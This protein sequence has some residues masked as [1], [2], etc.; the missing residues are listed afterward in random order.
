MRFPDRRVLDEHLEGGFIEDYLQI[1]FAEPAVNKISH[2]V[3][4]PFQENESF[5]DKEVDHQL[6]LNQASQQVLSHIFPWCV[7]TRRLFRHAGKFEAAHV[8]A[9]L[10]RWYEYY[11]PPP[12]AEDDENVGAS[13]STKG[14]GT[15]A[16]IMELMYLEE[17]QLIGQNSQNSTLV[18]EIQYVEPDYQVTDH[19][20][21]VESEP[22][23]VVFQEENMFPNRAVT[24]TMTN[25]MLSQSTTSIGNESTIGMYGNEVPD[26]PY[27]IYQDHYNVINMPEAWKIMKDLNAWPRAKYV[28]VHI[29]DS[30]WDIDHV[31]A[32]DNKWVNPDEDCTDDQKDPNKKDDDNNG[33]SDDCFGYNFADDTGSNIKGSN[34]HGSHCAGTISANTYNNL[35]VAGVAGGNKKNKGVQIMAGVVFGNSRN[36]GI[37]ESMTYGADMGAHISSNSWGFTTAGSYPQ[38]MKDAIAYAVERGVLVVFAAGNNGSSQKYY[39]AADDRV[40][41]VGSIEDNKKISDFSNWGDWVNIAAPGRRVLSTGFASEYLYSTGTSM[42]C[43]HVAGV[44]ALGKAVDPLATSAEMITCLYDTAIDIKEPKLGHGMINPP[45]YLNCISALRALPPTDQPNKSPSSSPSNFPTN[46]PTQTPSDVP[47]FVPTMSPSRIPSTPPSRV[48]SRFPTKAPTSFPSLEPSTTQSPSNVPSV[49]PS[50][51]PVR[52]RKWRSGGGRRVFGTSESTVDNQRNPRIVR[53]NASPT[54]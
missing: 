36:G 29:S 9:G 21:K 12:E 7:S 34:N 23:Q 52:R 44:L 8:E 47:S 30:G 2:E 33:F 45:G 46:R 32:G 24:K 40:V 42:A 37:A 31:D 5:E 35:G 28:N 25:T 41:T 20:L 18:V 26:D 27:L 13:N 16:A 6:L 53:S 19:S 22:A 15:H 38:S 17:Q 50:K 10:N 43:P 1:K 14:K 49:S 48:P 11:C 54:R 3:M 4:V 51:R 39:P